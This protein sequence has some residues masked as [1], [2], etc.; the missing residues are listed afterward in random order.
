[1]A[2]AWQLPGAQSVAHSAADF[3]PPSK[4]IQLRPPGFRP[5]EYPLPLHAGQQSLPTGSWPRPDA[6]QMTT[7]D[8]RQLNR[9]RREGDK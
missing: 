3:N 1:V 9:R 2:L 8:W 7:P 6:R 4:L 5:R